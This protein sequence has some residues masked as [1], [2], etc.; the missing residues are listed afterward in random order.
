VK[1][2][3]D[4]AA[5]AGLVAWVVVAA[6]CG[7]TG[8]READ[9]DA[10]PAAGAELRHLH[11]EGKEYRTPRAGEGFRTEVAGEEVTVPPRDRSTNTSW[12]VGAAFVAPGV[13]DQTVLPFASAY[14]WRRPDRDTFFRGV[15]VGL[16]NDL[17]FAKSAEQVRPLEGILAFTNYTIPLDQAEYVDGERIEDEEVTWGWVRPAFGFGIRDDLEHPGGNDNMFALS[18]LAEPSFVYFDDGRDTSDAFVVPEET[19]E[20]RAHLQMRFDALERNLLELPHS[21]FSMGGDAVYGYRAG[22]E[23]WGTNAEEDAGDTRDY[24][25]FSGFITAAG[26]VPFV[27]DD[28]HRLVGSVHGGT[29]V[30]ADRFSAFR[31]G[32]GPSPNGEEYEG[33][34]RAIIPGAFIEEFTTS[35]YAVLLGEYRWE[36]IFFLYL[37]LRGSVAFLERARFR[38][39]GIREQDDVLGSVG[40]RITTGFF[41]ETRL[42]VDY[43]WNAGVIRD[44]RFGGHE[45]VF[46]I[47]GQF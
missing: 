25:L 37:S 33:Q 39:G 44:G 17:V 8:S 7:S 11:E 46:H 31:V 34:A 15:I 41:F 1:P 38:D 29:A 40:T 4:P 43:N 2:A 19:F 9:P 5:I 6:G 18:L 22:W 27:R 26:G 12:D 3:R 16:Y 24:G 21:G 35:R 10:Q 32:G 23:D 20:P 42:Q 13:E 47:S 36:P 28:R 30:D 14:L 45:V